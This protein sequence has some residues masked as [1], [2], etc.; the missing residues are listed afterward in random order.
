MNFM[1]SKTIS[2][3]PVDGSAPFLTKYIALNGGPAILG[4]EKIAGNGTA[5]A[6]NGL[7]AIVGDE[8]TDLPI[9]VVHAELYAENGHIYI[10][11]LDSVHGTWVDGEKVT[12]AR[13]L[14]T[15]SIIVSLRLSLAPNKLAYEQL[16]YVL[17]VDRNLAYRSSD[18]KAHQRPYRT[19]H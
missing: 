3:S 1:L 5:A 2:L 15:G 4:R 18:H 14:D 17:G 8:F 13:L 11:D 19:T 12:T 7:F 16:T 9:S 10:K 6:T